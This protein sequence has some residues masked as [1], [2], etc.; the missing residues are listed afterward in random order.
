MRPAWRS[1]ISFGRRLL[2]RMKEKQFDTPGISPLWHFRDREQIGSCQRWWG[3]RADWRIGRQTF[4]GGSS[5]WWPRQREGW[6]TV[7]G[8]FANKNPWQVCQLGRANHLGQPESEKKEKM[9]LRKLQ[10]DCLIVVWISRWDLDMELVGF[11]YLTI[12]P[13]V[14]SIP[15][16][17]LLKVHCTSRYPISQHQLLSFPFCQLNGG[18]LPGRQPNIKRTTSNIGLD[19][20]ARKVYLD[21]NAWLTCIFGCGASTHLDCRQCC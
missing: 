7:Q 17:L 20:C 16:C 8:K 5:H 21:S 2:K 3:E 12:V 13:K 15:S 18:C 14:L 1:N 6:T 4:C 11:S 9:L 19:Q 10:T